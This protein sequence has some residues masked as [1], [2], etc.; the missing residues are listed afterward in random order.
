MDKGDVTHM[1]TH[2]NNGILV[3]HEKEGSPAVCSNVDGPCKCYVKLNK[4]DREIQILYITY[5]WNLIKDHL[6]ETMK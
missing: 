3:S 6:M 2:T 1:P 5:M 4:L